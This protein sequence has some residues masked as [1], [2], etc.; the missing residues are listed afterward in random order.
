MKYQKGM[1]FVAWDSVL[2]GHFWPFVWS[3]ALFGSK[4]SVQAEF[5]HEVA[6]FLCLP[7]LNGSAA[8]VLSHKPVR[9]SPSCTAWSAA[10]GA[11]MWQSGTVLLPCLL[12]H[13]TGLGLKSQNVKL[14]PPAPST[15]LPFTCCT[16]AVV[17]ACTSAQ[18]LVRLA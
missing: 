16:C 13:A 15:A 5:Q 7:Q 4:M 3:V 2:K 11:S 1:A 12:L 14:L 6:N 10:L 17:L 9:L 8:A 18:V